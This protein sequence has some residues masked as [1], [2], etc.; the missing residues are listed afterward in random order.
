MCPVNAPENC[1]DHNPGSKRYKFNTMSNEFL[2]TDTWQNILD[3]LI[4]RLESTNPCQDGID[5]L[6]DKM[7][8]EIFEEMDEYIEYKQA[9]KT[10]RKLYRNHKP[11]WT[12]ELTDAWKDMSLS[13]RKYFDKLLRRTERAY[14]RSKAT[15]IEKNKY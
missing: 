12:D 4:S 15:E 8:V 7:M 1:N 9:S 5:K 11:F 3:S 2:K 14:N 6:Y 10:T 13:K